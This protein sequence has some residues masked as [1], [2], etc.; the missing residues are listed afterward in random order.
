MEALL[1]VDLLEQPSVVNKTPLGVAFLH[2]GKP[3][4]GYVAELS[5][6]IQPCISVS[7]PQPADKGIEQGFDG[8]C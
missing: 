8:R 6:D 4:L 1:Y 2:H 5:K 3:F 7:V